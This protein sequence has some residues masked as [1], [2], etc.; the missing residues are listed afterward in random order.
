MNEQNGK[1]DRSVEFYWA[2]IVPIRTPTVLRAV[3]V[4]PNLV[5]ELYKTRLDVALNTCTNRRPIVRA[6]W[7]RNLPEYAAVTVTDCRW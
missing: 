3:L 5:G 7:E 2:D 4:E 1:Q 6:C